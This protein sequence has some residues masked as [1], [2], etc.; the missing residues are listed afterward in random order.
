M[1]R[2]DEFRAIAVR[3][4][5][6]AL[7]DLPAQPVSKYV[8]RTERPEPLPADSGAFLYRRIDLL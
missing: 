8:E 4:A 6:V 5:R 3:V 2:R 1:R 7:L